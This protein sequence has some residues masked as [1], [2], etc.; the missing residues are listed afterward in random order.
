MYV[1]PQFAE[2]DPEKLF[3]FVEQHSFGLLVSNLDGRPFA[4]HLPLLVD[5]NAGPHGALVGHMAR[6]NPQWTSDDRQVL[7]VFSG[8][9]AYI[10]PT[11][12]EAVDVVPTWNY[13]AVHVYGTLAVE[14]DHA[15]TLAIVRDYV[16]FYER[17]MPRPWTITDEN[18]YIDRMAHAVVGFRIAIERIE[19]KWK[20]N[21][22]HPR[23]R[24]ER[25]A[26][27]LAQRP[28]ENSQAIARAMTESLE[29]P[30]SP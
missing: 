2:T 26:R 7:A 3:D 11:W 17:A 10:T 1:P 13:L 14:E 8:P 12:Y 9:H 18:K 25:V 30:E 27:A 19:G 21:Q 29:T 15:A 5:R 16:A 28:D 6:A 4:S 23:A 22:N 24:R 20:L